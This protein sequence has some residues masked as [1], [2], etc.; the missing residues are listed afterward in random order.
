MK[1]YLT[2]D[3]GPHPEI[4]PYVLEQLALFQAKATFFCIGEQV[5]KYP[6]VY[7]QIL[8]A[9]HR[10][11][12][13]T[14]SH[15]NGWK[16]SDEKYFKDVEKAAAVI[17]SKLFRPPYGKIRRFQL[18]IITGERLGLRPVMWHVLSGDFDTSLKPEQCYLNVVKNTSPGSIIVF[19]DSEK[20]FPRLKDTL[21][22]ALKYLKDKGFSFDILD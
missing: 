19:H 20:A 7:Q 22:K 14:Y 8:D 6:E 21:P 2:F 16:T 5:E 9:G 1:V 13:H 4:T 17:K 18:K 12:N 15:L 11:G 3:D 10:T